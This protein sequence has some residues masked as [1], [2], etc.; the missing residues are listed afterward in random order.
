MH[1][2]GPIL[3]EDVAVATFPRSSDAV[4]L[5]WYQPGA[6]RSCGTRQCTEFR[7]TDADRP[8]AR[9]ATTRPAPVCTFTQIAA[10]LLRSKETVVSVRTFFGDAP[11]LEIEGP[12]S[13]PGGDVLS[14]GVGVGSGDSEGDGDGDGDAL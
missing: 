2:G 9:L 8:F 13:D 12:A 1:G 10:S 5:T 3:T 6:G 4:I 7:P 14:L 11:R